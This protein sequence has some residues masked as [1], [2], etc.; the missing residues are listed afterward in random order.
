MYFTRIFWYKNYLLEFILIVAN[1][2][3]VIPWDN[4]Y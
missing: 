3:N 1:R 2:R 4:F